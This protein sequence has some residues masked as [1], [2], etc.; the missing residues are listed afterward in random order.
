MLYKT[1]VF[2]NAVCH[3]KVRYYGNIATVLY[4]NAPLK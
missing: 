1:T 4:E 3:S 2:K